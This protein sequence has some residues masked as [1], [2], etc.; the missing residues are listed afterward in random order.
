LEVTVK[1]I[2]I[3]AAAALTFAAALSPAPVRAQNSQTFV[4][5]ANG[6][7]SN[8]CSRRSPCRTFA[9][10]ITQTDPGGEISALD[11]GRYGPVF[12]TK[13]ISIVGGLGEVSILVSSGEGIVINAG[14]NDAITLRG[15]VIEGGGLGQL[16]V[17]FRAGKSLTIEKCIVRNFPD[18]AIAFVP[19]AASNLTVSDTLLLDNGQGIGVSPN[20]AVTVTAAFN[21]V[22]AFNNRTNGFTLN[23]LS[24]RINATAADSVAAGSGTI[25]FSAA[26]QSGKTSLMLVRS[27]IANNNFGLVASGE[28]AVIRVGQSTV[29]GN[30]NGWTTQTGGV[31]QSYRDNKIDGNDSNEGPP[32]PIP[33][34]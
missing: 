31:V 16:G 17:V 29:S 20:G 19:S 10:A 26:T 14:A 24:A 3:S 4:S 21:R 8:D 28:G 2:T 23:G 27:V 18:T 13:S 1:R 25:G 34:K 11:P 22:A 32:P 15:L 7:D 30:I 6:N 5:A 33:N 9:F 12:I